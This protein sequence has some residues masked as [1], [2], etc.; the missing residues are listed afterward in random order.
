MFSAS[1]GNVAKP[2]GRRVSIGSYVFCE[3]QGMDSCS[4]H[5]FKTSWG[6]TSFLYIY[7]YTHTL[8]FI[9]VSW[10]CHLTLYCLCFLPYLGK[11]FW[12]QI[13][14]VLLEACNLYFWGCLG[15]CSTL[16]GSKCLSYW[17]NISVMLVVRW[18]FKLLFL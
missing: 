6:I 18:K 10:G 1:N 14:V 4:G 2:V 13:L 5:T 17:D 12:S 8:A 15:I 16:K 7:I 3:V 11:L 9:V